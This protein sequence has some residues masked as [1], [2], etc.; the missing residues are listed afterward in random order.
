MPESAV[1][2]LPASES[3]VPALPANSSLC[4]GSVRALH[5]EQCYRSVRTLQDRRAIS[6]NF[7][8]PEVLRN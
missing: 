5:D 2:A 8:T 4:I 6:M 1:P 3:A 7:N